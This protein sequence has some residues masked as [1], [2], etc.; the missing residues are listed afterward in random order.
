[1]NPGATFDRVYLEVRGRLLAGVWRP[2]QRIDL[3]G[4]ADSLDTSVTPV[5]DALYRLVGERL[6]ELGVSDGFVTIGITE[7]DLCDQYAW[8][9]MLLLLCIATQ[10]KKVDYSAFP[11]KKT[12]ESQA[13]Q[14]FS[15]IAAQTPNIEL[16]AAVVAVG[17]RLSYVRRIE[18]LIGITAEVEEQELVNVARNYDSVALKS[19]II[20]YHK[21]RIR[22]A[23]QTVKA[24]HRQR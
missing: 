2:S 20:R 19:I 11:L 10:P 1:M 7:P 23:G 3:V 21:R 18:V 13:A 8:N 16:S 22:L 9:Q 6:L 17:N 15:A 5:R 14:L 12:M 24:M 4:L